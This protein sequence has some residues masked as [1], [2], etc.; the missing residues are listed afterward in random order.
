MPTQGFRAQVCPHHGPTAASCPAQVAEPQPVDDADADSGGWQWATTE[1][2]SQGSQ[3]GQIAGA[4][5][6]MGDTARQA[7][8]CCLQ[9]PRSAQA[10]SP[11]TAE[12]QSLSPGHSAQDKTHHQLGL[13]KE[14][15]PSWDHR[16]GT[17]LGTSMEPKSSRAMGCNYWAQTYCHE[18]RTHRTG[19]PSPL[20]ATGPWVNMCLLG[21]WGSS[22]IPVGTM[23][24][25][26]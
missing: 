24:R 5:L 1:L 6:G 12:G 16:R 19:H 15:R 13:T 7:E 2:R 26:K 20:L 17:A 22:R 3:R 9:A 11:S 21:G 23:H 10:P 4:K 14:P 18:Q 25:G 8:E